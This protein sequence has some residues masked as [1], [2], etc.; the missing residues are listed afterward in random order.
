MIKIAVANQ[1]GGVGKTTTALNIADALKHCGYRVLFID[2][3]PQCN[4]TSSYGAQI[5]DTNT[6]YNLMNDN[7]T[8]ENAIQ[9]MPMGDI[10]AGDPHLP[11]D[12]S[13]FLTKIGGFNILAKAL[14]SVENDYDYAL[15]DT[16]PNLGIFMVNALVAA[17][18]VIIPI[19][20]EKYAIDGLGK[21][22]GTVNDVIENGNNKLQVYGVLMTAYDVRNSLDKEIWRVLPET[23][24]NYGFPVFKTPVRICQVVKEA[25]AENVS[26]FDKNP[27]CNAAVDYANVVKELL[28]RTE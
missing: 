22:I 20:A 12:E 17:T 14:K 9:H 21:L 26:L 15:I 23:G 6:I 11:E 27:T 3:D 28:G 13:K 4:S 16:P 10:I 25:Q 5:D 2:M 19:K 1:K 18:G 7:C 24:E 8:V